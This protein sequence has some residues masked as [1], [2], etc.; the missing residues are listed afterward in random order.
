[1][2]ILD[3]LLDSLLDTLKALPF[4]YLAFLLMEFCE[5]KAGSRINHWL[6]SSRWWGAPIGAI[7]GLIPQCGFSVAAANLYAGGL[8]SLGTLLSV[9]LSTSDEA[10]LIL[11]GQSN[12]FS[13]IWQ[14][15]LCKFVIGT[16]AGLLID[17]FSGKQ[18]QQRD[19][20]HFCASCGCHGDHSLPMAALH[21]TIHTLIPLFLFTF[22]IGLVME[23]IGQDA[24]A[25]I[26]F[27]GSPLQPLIAGLI[28]LIP[29]CASSVLLTQLYLTE[30][31]SFASLLAGLCANSG[32]ALLLL[33]K[34]NVSHK[35]NFTIL[36]MLY[37]IS[38][39]CGIFLQ[40]IF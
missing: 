1:M 23:W 7:C 10:L 20:E 2:M 28:G 6:T 18:R 17:L 33:F 24:F 4:L 38:A 11:L 9:F 36:G 40:F 34:S 26:L 37:G 30:V 29:N 35:E 25:S 8:I 12:D 32:V 13:V 5:H 27:K 16:T 39:L 14:L 15:L 3:L 22:L 21:H 31:L 19:M